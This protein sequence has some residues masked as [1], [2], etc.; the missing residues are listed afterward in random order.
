[1]PTAAAIAPLTLP[2]ATGGDGD[3]SYGLDPQVPGLTFQP[4][5]RTLTGTPG[6]AGEYAMTYTATDADDNTDPSDAAV[7]RFTITVTEPEPPNQ[8]PYASVEIQS[9]T[10]QVR[11][12]TVSARYHLTDYFRDPDGDP[13]ASMPPAATLRWRPPM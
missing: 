8:P 3:L 11:I 10:L 12:G 6:A 13:L 7:L 4:V 9:R 2:A 1:M 5:T